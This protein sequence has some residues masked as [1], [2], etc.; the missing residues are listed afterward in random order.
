[1]ET[2]DNFLKKAVEKENNRGIVSVPTREQYPS[3]VDVINSEAELY[4]T[5]FSP[6]ELEALNV[7]GLTAEDLIEN[8]SARRYLVMLVGG[9][10]AGFTSWYPK[11]NQVAWISMLHVSQRSQGKGIGTKLLE[12][13]ECQAKEIGMRAV[14]LEAQRK[15][16]WA[17]SF[18]LKRGYEILG[19]DKLNAEPYTGTL[20]KPPVESTY[21]F[22]KV[23]N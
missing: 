6:E 12:T 22:G 10:L 11:D 17:V 4:K 18:Y 21:V 13:V 2:E 9:E 7:G 5:T 20:S 16:S 23:L 14:A 15:A 8:E 3:I 1:M 19:W